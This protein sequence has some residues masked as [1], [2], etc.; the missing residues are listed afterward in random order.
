[1]FFQ[2]YGNCTFIT[3]GD[4]GRGLSLCREQFLVAS[5]IHQMSSPQVPYHKSKA[6]KS[7]NSSAV[8]LQ[9]CRLHPGLKSRRRVAQRLSWGANTTQPSTEAPSFTYIYMQKLPSA[10]GGRLARCIWDFAISKQQAKAISKVG[11]CC[12]KSYKT[13]FS[14]S[15]N[16]SIVL[17]PN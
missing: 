2:Q 5:I 14:A 4:M 6:E 16:T 17:W 8:G 11:K 10:S 15:N 13:A 7:W 1:M 12:V 9:H 3:R